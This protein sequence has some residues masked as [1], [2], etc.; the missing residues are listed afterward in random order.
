MANIVTCSKCNGTGKF[1]YQSGMI[2]QCYN[3]DGIGQLKQTEQKQYSISIVDCDNNNRIQWIHVDAKTEKAAIKKAETIALR[4][5]YKDNI[6][7][8]QAEEKGIIYKY[9][10]IKK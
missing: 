10:K 4:G 9:S 8:I 2:G 6:D 3:C 1:H 7:T 5:C